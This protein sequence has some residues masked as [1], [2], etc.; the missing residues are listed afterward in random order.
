MKK[1]KVITSCISIAT[2]KEFVEKVFE[3][4]ETQKSSYVCCANVHMVVEAYKDPLFNQ[5][6][7]N[8]DL[9]SP[10]GRPISL[11]ISFF[12][13]IKQ[14]RIAGMDLVPCLLQEAERRKKSVYFYGSTQE[15]LL[16]IV[17]KIH[18]DFPNLRIAGTYSP[19][20]RVL[21]QEEEEAII[22]TINEA[23]P[24]LLFVSLG[25]PK[26]EKWMATH[27]NTIIA[28]MLGVGQAFLTYAGLEKR[29]PKWAR[30]FALEWAYR[31]YLEP[32]RLWK[33]Y[34][35]TNSTFLFLM[36][37]RLIAGKY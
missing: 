24:D 28:C 14:E 7:N 5:V 26:Q 27:K 13:K 23:K 4:S 33:R 31:L 3:L 10:D 1:V 32:R 22:Q 30:D 15:V 21:S 16:R 8:A 19:P 12:N 17:Q 29:A 34:V 37:K 25:C 36:L 11:A 2:F 18:Q 35:V 9:V 20:F 6:L